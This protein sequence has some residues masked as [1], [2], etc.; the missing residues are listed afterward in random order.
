MVI[1]PAIWHAFELR[2]RSIRRLVLQMEMDDGHLTLQSLESVDSESRLRLMTKEGVL[3]GSTAVT[4]PS[5]V[6]FC[7]TK[8]PKSEWFLR[9]VIFLYAVQWGV[10]ADTYRF[11]LHLLSVSDVSLS[12]ELLLFQF[13]FCFMQTADHSPMIARHLAG[14]RARVLACLETQ[15][16][17]W[18]SACARP[19]YAA[20]VRQLADVKKTI[21]TMAALFPFAPAVLCEMSIFEADVAR[22]T[23]RAADA[24]SA[25]TTVMHARAEHVCRALY[26]GFSQFLAAPSPPIEDFAA[27][28]SRF[29]SLRETCEDAHRLASAVLPKDAWLKTYAR[30][31]T[32]EADGDPVRPVVHR[33]WPVLTVVEVIA[34]VA[35]VAGVAVARTLADR[36]SEHA[37]CAS[38]HAEA[39]A[40]T[41]EFRD[42]VHNV[43][44]D[45]GILLNVIA[46]TFGERNEQLYLQTQLNLEEAP[47]KLTMFKAVCD[48][49]ESLG[50]AVPGPF[51]ADLVAFLELAVAP[52][53]GTPVSIDQVEEIWGRLYAHSEVIFNGIYNHTRSSIP[54][55]LRKT[56]QLF[57]ATAG[58]EVSAGLAL[59]VIAHFLL[60][61]LVMQ[62]LDVI[63]TA[64]PP[65]MDE[66]AHTFDRIIRPTAHPTGRCTPVLTVSLPLFLM[67]LLLSVYPFVTAVAICASPVF[68]PAPA[69]PAASF[70]TLEQDFMLYSIAETEA[71]LIAKGVLRTCGTGCYHSVTKLAVD[72]PTFSVFA[73]SPQA[74]IVWSGATAILPGLIC[75][76][77]VAACACAR[78]FRLGEIVLRAFPQ[79]AIR[80][81]PVLQRLALGG[82]I[83]DSEIRA[84][85]DS[86]KAVPEV[87]DFLCLIDVD[88]AG[89]VVRTRGRPSEL[90]GITPSAIGD[91]VAAL[92]RNCPEL[93]AFCEER[94]DGSAV[95]VV[96]QD[97]RAISMTFGEHGKS[98][99]IKDD[100][101]NMDANQKARLMG[102]LDALI[103]RVARMP[104]E[105]D[106]AVLIGIESNV[107]VSEICEAP[108][109]VVDQRNGVQLF[110]A[111]AA[112]P[113]ACERAFAFLRRVRSSADSVTA[114]AHIGGPIRIFESKAP[115]AKPRCVAQVYDELRQLLR[116]IPRRTVAV[117]REL[118]Q[119]SSAEISG[120]AFRQIRVAADREIDVA[121]L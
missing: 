70:F 69:L 35:F 91:I 99:V 87:P 79:I 107:D 56:R 7:L 109:I 105:I 106:Q 101:N 42:V 39:L 46:E 95:N 17:F 116:L 59:A 2:R 115:I 45:L 67:F 53:H 14:Y 18:L 97:G 78:D 84:F 29:L 21:R 85:V 19:L 108:I 31:F 51:A 47:E 110:L 13:V 62:V 8:Y 89:T 28:G 113:A 88:D 6:L 65:V 119:Q 57:L 1:F 9:Y 117:T 58:C 64:Q 61:K 100:A 11:L 102:R 63:S 52:R 93:A 22:R 81:N 66:I 10:Q 72:S 20:L 5:F 74:I 54:P 4:S 94:A 25:A 118:L 111:D 121:M 83:G 33:W 73:L 24:Y 48:H 80:S 16:A 43:R 27:Q 3:A 114:V 12:T 60:K 37:L 120:T 71:D 49:M 50:V 82:G 23:A 96:T 92:G 75:A 76:A 104:R 26:L 86:V 41:L 90:I 34:V 36:L 98:L 103:E 15:R 55:G 30:V 44:I 38:D 32:H 68:P 112:F 40:A 77:F